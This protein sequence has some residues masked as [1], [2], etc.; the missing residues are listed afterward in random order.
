MTFE[1]VLKIYNWKKEKSNTLNL[2]FVK[3]IF[4][5]IKEVYKKKAIE[6]GR[7]ANQSW[8]SWMGHNFEKLITNIVKDY[9]VSVDPRIGITSDD[10]LR[11]DKLAPIL[12]RVRRNLE[13][14]YKRYSILPDADIVIYDKSTSGIIAI[15][16]CK[17]SL[18]ERVAQAAYWKIKLLNS[19][20]TSNILYFLVST[21][22]DGD[23]TTTGED[24]KRNRIIVEEGEIDGA[25]IF[26]DDVPESDKVKHFHKI[27]DDLKQLIEGFYER[28]KRDQERN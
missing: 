27:F 4:D 28:C 13:I 3:E 6:I 12:D 26:R 1:D 17:S 20:V 11:S 9:V 25:Y 10:E 8:N 15:L 21:D 22:N 2:N 16:S 5:E 19:S 23:F 14:F 18:R 7:D 24:I